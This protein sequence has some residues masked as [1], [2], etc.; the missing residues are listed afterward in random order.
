MKRI[1]AY[2]I[3][4]VEIM[5]VSLM[6][7]DYRLQ[8]WHCHY[9]GKLE[10]MEKPASELRTKQVVVL[11][12]SG[13]GVISKPTD[14]EQAIR[15]RNDAGT[16]VWTEYKGILSFV[17]RERLGSLYEKLAEWQIFPQ[18][19]YIALSIEQAVMQYI[20]SLGW[21]SLIRLTN[22]GSALAQVV[23]RRIKL[24]VLCFFLALLTINVFIE[25]SIN[26]RRQSLQSDIALL[27]RATSGAVST[28]MRQRQL[29]DNFIE[30]R[31]IAGSVLCDRIAAALPEDIILQKLEVE[32]PDMRIEAGKPLERK[33]GYVLIHGTAPG[34]SQISAFTEKLSNQRLLHDLRLITVD[35]NPGEK[36]LS[37][38]IE[39]R[40]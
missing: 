21:R 29:L 39:A 18:G 32:P 35:R 2:L 33:I 31:S 11:V 30:S 15:I 25:S 16:F 9:H 27:K 19:V 24:P 13:Y 28:N 10:R 1:L 8:V 22:E 12:I 17:R 3:S 26:D 6:S 20:D 34:P 40:L 38:K 7:N 4:P 14:S 5:D 37:F 36:Q 23:T